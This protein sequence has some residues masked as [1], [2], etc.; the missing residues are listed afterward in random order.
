MQKKYIEISKLP[1]FEVTVTGGKKF[2]L[3]P[4]EHLSDIP[5][6]NVIEPVRCKDCKHFMEYRGTFRPD[7]EEANGD[8]YI[9]V[10]NSDNHQFW[11]VQYDDFCSFGE[12]GEPDIPCVST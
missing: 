4:F 10:T 6:A 12:K 7:V 5:T 3:L 2:L 11:A 9:R 1:N 8:C